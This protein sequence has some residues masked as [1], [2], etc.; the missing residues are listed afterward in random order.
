M[1]VEAIPVDL[2]LVGA[3]LFSIVSALDQYSWPRCE[4]VVAA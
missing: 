3:A 4:T 2:R 1:K